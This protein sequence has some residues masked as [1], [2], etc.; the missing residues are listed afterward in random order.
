MEN[1]DFI[2]STIGKNSTKAF[3]VELMELPE[4]AIQASEK[5]GLLDLPTEEIYEIFNNMTKAAYMSSKISATYL[6]RY[7]STEDYAMKLV[8][9][10]ESLI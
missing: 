7:V 2:L 3:L 10:M 8:N 9:R 4:W 5:L 1:F 6:I